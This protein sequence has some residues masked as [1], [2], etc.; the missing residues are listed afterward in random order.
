MTWRTRPEPGLGTHLSSSDGPT[1]ATVRLV[2]DPSNRIAL[3]PFLPSIERLGKPLLHCQFARESVL[4]GRSSFGDLNARL[5]KGQGVVLTSRNFTSITSGVNFSFFSAVQRLVF[6][7]TRSTNSCL[8]ISSE[9]IA[10]QTTA[11]RRIQ[12]L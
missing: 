6:D 7:L 4:N 5:S 1:G 11:R 9:E 10:G 2:P 3:G 12:M 8:D